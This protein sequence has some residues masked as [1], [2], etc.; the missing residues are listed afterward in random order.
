MDR[1]DGEVVFLG[2]SL[3]LRDNFPSM[4]PKGV[5][6]MREARKDALGKFES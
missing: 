5:S 1:R 6:D 4:K 2:V 3:Y